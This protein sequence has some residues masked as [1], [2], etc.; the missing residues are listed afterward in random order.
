MVAEKPHLLI[1]HPGGKLE[2]CALDYDAAADRLTL[3]GASF[4]PEGKVVF[5]HH[6]PALPPSTPVGGTQP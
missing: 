3:S 1:H 2:D 5:A 6:R 4:H